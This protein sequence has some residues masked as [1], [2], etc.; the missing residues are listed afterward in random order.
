MRGDLHVQFGG[1]GYP[2]VNS[3][4][5]NLFIYYG[6]D[7]N[8]RGFSHQL[9]CS[10]EPLRLL[11]RTQVPASRKK[12]S[13]SKVTFIPTAHLNVVGKEFIESFATNSFIFE[14][15]PETAITASYRLNE[16]KLNETKRRK[17]GIIEKG[18]VYRYEQAR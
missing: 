15:Q 10:H 14:L 2:D 8:G 3:N 16:R 9:C 11:E 18:E 4:G 6:I 1:R 12:H 5:T 17:T 7:S 13:L